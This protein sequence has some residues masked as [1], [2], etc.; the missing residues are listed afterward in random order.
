MK[1]LYISVFHPELHRGGAQQVTYELFEAMKSVPG[2]EPVFLAAVDPSH[3]AFY[4]AGARITGFD[5]GT[6]IVE[7]LARLTDDSAAP[8]AGA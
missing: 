2:V 1:V 8:R 4:K 7:P 6:L 3:R 5:G